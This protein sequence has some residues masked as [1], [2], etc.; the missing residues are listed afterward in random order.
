MLVSR[1]TGHV[2]SF[3]FGT[4]T[5]GDL[6][7]GA[8]REWL[9]TDG[10]GGFAMGTVSGLRTRRYHGLLVVAGEVPARRMLGLAALDL[11]VTQ[12]S[13]ALVRLGVH[14]WASGAVEPQGYALMESFEL[15]DGVP[16]WRWRVGSVVVER[17]LAMRRGE[18]SVA[19]VHRVLAGGP[20]TLSVEALC[21]WRDVHGERNESAG[22]SLLTSPDGVVV[23]GA[24]RVSGPSFEADLQWFRGAAHREERDRGL[25]PTED[26]LRVGRFVQTVDTG[27]TL[28]VSA[29]AGDLARTPLAAA[30]VVNQARQ[31]T[32]TLRAGLDGDA[33]DL[34]VAADAFVVR[35]GGGPPDVVAGY[36]WFGTWS[37]DTM[38]S[39][40]GL[41]LTTN[42]VDEGRELLRAYA[43]MLSD[44]MLANTADTGQ[45]EYNT[46]DATLWF[47][48]AVDR[49]VAAT[50]DADLAA[51]LIDD[52]E[53]IIRHHIA[54]TRF[55]IRIDP[56]DGLLTQGAPGCALTWMDAV[57]NGVPITPRTGKAVELNALWINGLAAVAALGR[58]LRRDVTDFERRRARAVDS[59]VRRFPCERGWL[60]DVLDSTGGD[61]S[62][63]RPN[64]LFAYGLP[65]APLRGGDPGPVKA[66]AQML[67]TPLGLRTLAPDDPAYRG[68]HRGD[69]AARD[70]AYH[71]GTV[72]PWLLGA[73]ADAADAVGQR[74]DG[75]LN[76]VR[77]HLPE[78][79]VGSISETADGDAPH[80][81]T[82]CP[83]QAWSVAE[84]LRTLTTERR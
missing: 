6:H 60:Y 27:E 25:S 62:A 48:H 44:G 55:G 4:Q 35:P 67:L 63:M 84:V 65:Y 8:Q 11:A 22:L 26:L 56:A 42:R 29:W 46:A 70:G 50:G 52:L 77:A 14:E 21:T 2:A 41:F 38:I 19:V 54:G 9:V 74:S 40:A 51:E 17:E 34:Q 28:Q 20:V 18:A 47:L 69:P 7:L 71:Q 1:H 31:R 59:F 10:L 5:C 30:E 75:L 64:Q 32:R 36:P 57:V 68:A 80:A 78:W 45:V 15:R 79:G 82:G 3:R 12:P 81:A 23:E 49:H 43:R 58:P 76:G 83:F 61:D 66:V 73:F 16:V 24:Y 72:W 13:G 37:R 39:Y 53:Q 33:A